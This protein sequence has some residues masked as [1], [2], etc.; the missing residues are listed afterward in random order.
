MEVEIVNPK[1]V[2]ERQINIKST[3]ISLS[4]LYSGDYTEMYIDGHFI[5]LE[6]PQLDQLYEV[7]IKLYNMLEG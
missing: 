3:D 1:S 2:F 5:A 7:L 6:K 4:N